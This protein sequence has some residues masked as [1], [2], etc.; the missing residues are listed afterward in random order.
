MTNFIPVFPLSAVAFPDEDLNL[1]IFEPRYIQLV[2]DCAEQEKPFGI[3]VVL[4]NT[5]KESGTLMEIVE[6]VSKYESGAMDIRTRGL[7]VFR[8]LEFVKNL[9]DKLYGGAIVNYPENQI[10]KIHPNLSDLIVN[11]VKR[12]YHL[13][14][15]D[16]KFNLDNIEWSSYDIAHKI[17]LSQEQEY[18]LLQL[19]NE[20]QRLE[21]IRRHLKKMQP[22]IEE[23]AILKKRIQLN[24]HFKNLSSPDIN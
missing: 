16:N 8:I 20:T 12:T 3:P 6:I 5:L 18:E 14:G 22:V 24:G 15:L 2:N 21:F 10:V 23:L 11:E 9:P 4:G 7:K 13:L 19:F 1:H 17:G